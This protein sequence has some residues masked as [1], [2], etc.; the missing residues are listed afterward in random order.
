MNRWVALSSNDDRNEHNTIAFNN[1]LK[2]NMLQ[3]HEG[4]DESQSDIAPVTPTQKSNI[5]S[6]RNPRQQSVKIRE[7]G[8]KKYYDGYD[9]DG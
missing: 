8:Q 1:D 9:S 7:E 5:L 4:G 2:H 6:F 3:F